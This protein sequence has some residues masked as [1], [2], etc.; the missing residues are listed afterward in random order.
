MGL[1]R[2]LPHLNASMNATSA[3]CLVLGFYYIRNKRVAEHKRCMLAAVTASTIFLIGYLSRHALTGTTYFQGGDTARRVYHCILYSHM[4]LAVVTAPLVLR[5]LF[6]AKKE[7]FE[8]H[9]RLG[10]WI[11]PVWLYVSITGIVVYMMLYH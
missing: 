1:A 10:R 9:K 4:T 5:M 6:L 11:F 3:V 7:R 2:V 8:E